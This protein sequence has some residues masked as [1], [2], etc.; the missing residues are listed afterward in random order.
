[1]STDSVNTVIPPTKNGQKIWPR[2][3]CIHVRAN[4]NHLV[5][6]F[7][8]ARTKLTPAREFLQAFSPQ[9]QIKTLNPLPN[10][11]LIC[12]KNCS[13]F[14]TRKTTLKLLQEL[15]HQN[16][17]ILRSAWITWKF[18]REQ[19]T[20]QFNLEV[21]QK[22]PLEVLETVMTGVKRDREELLTSVTH[23]IPPDQMTKIW[24][25]HI[26]IKEPET[27]T[28]QKR[29][30]EETTDDIRKAIMEAMEI[31][32]NLPMEERAVVAEHNPT[33]LKGLPTDRTKWTEGDWKRVR[34]I[35]KWKVQHGT[36]SS[37]EKNH[38]QEDSPDE[39]QTSPLQIMV[40]TGTSH[41]PDTQPIRPDIELQSSPIWE[42]P[43][44]PEPKLKRL[45]YLLEISRDGYSILSDTVLNGFRIL[46]L[47]TPFLNESSNTSNNTEE[48]KTQ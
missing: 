18:E 7:E 4:Q 24:V 40:T 3:Y 2:T 38:N 23:Q 26:E 15:Q 27:P 5:N 22:P 32:W 14:Q 19:E 25:H 34:L 11:F 20:E 13:S 29:Q 39:R 46:V 21:N 10:N 48:T 35:N 42:L 37:S 16:K 41:T 31:D 12:L 8:N 9:V 28:P 17:L 47:A 45:R 1:M 30:A 6:C 33:L 36:P 44:L 43:L